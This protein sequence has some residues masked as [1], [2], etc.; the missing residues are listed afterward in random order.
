MKKKSGKKI[1]GKKTTRKTNKMTRVE[2]RIY[3]CFDQRKD[4]D[5]F[6][7]EIDNEK[8]EVV[9]ADRMKSLV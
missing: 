6:Q 8:K 2:R 9:S 5:F 4:F 7:N 3:H 1:R